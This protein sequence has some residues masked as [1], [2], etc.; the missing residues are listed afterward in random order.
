M[1]SL[2][3][4]TT[5]R[6]GRANPIRRIAVT[7]EAEG[8]AEI[9]P[10][11]EGRTVTGALYSAKSREKRAMYALSRRN[12]LLGLALLG[13]GSTVAAAARSEAA[14]KAPLAIKGYDPVAYFTIGS[15]TRGLPDLEF[16]WDEHLYR[17][18]RPEHRELFRADPVRYAPQFANVCTM[19]LTR[20]EIEEAS[21]EYW[22]VSA[23][24]LYLFGKPIGPEIFQRDLAEN[25]VKA[26]QN[27]S[28][29]QKR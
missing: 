10:N 20:G 3:G 22:L 28:Q 24:K 25:V 27:R 11:S 6:R 7:K 5:Q 4:A 14:E 29:I 23:G 19:A 12:V 26:N 9:S 8:N 16:E 15:P 13:A 1:A 17:F 21:P 2:A 18:S